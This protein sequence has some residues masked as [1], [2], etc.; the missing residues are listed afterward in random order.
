MQ[1]TTYPI[2]GSFHQLLT[3]GE[4]VPSF[5]YEVSAG[6][7]WQGR[8]P[9]KVISNPTTDAVLNRIFLDHYIFY[10]PWRL[11]WDQWPEFISQR[12]T[13]QDG[14]QSIPTQVPLMK[15]TTPT[16]RDWET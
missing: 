7:S 15:G 11:V 10:V 4:I 14:N 5:Y 9:F 2:S 16:D 3:P 13:G 6:E 8:I 1:T 12:S